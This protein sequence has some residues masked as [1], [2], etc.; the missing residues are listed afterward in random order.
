MFHVPG[1]IDDRNK[2]HSFPWGRFIFFDFSELAVRTR[3][4]TFPS[5]SRDNIASWKRWRSNTCCLQCVR[6]AKS[7]GWVNFFTIKN[8]VWSDNKSIKLLIELILPY[9]TVEWI[10]NS[11]LNLTFVAGLRFIERIPTTWLGS[12]TRLMCKLNRGS[13]FCYSQTTGDWV[14]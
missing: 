13:N 4:P 3:S 6:V 7:F 14:I 12:S 8:A 9:N 10:K 11:V 5:Q 2:T 1:F